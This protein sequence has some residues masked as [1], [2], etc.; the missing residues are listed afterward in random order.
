M[1]NPMQ[2]ARAINAGKMRRVAMTSEA[3]KNL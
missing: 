2:Q 1:A 3:I